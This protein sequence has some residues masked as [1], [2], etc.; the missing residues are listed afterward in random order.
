[1][2]DIRFLLDFVAENKIPPIKRRSFLSSIIYFDI[3]G[4]SQFHLFNLMANFLNIV[5]IA[6][7]LSEK[8]LDKELI[9]VEFTERD[10]RRRRIPWNSPVERHVSIRSRSFA[11]SCDGSVRD[12]L[13]TA[14]RVLLT[15]ESFSSRGNTS[16]STCLELKA[17]E[18]STPD[19]GQQIDR[20]FFASV[21][22]AMVNV[23]QM[24][25]DFFP[26]LLQFGSADS[27]FMQTSTQ[28]LS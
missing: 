16:S 1:M 23:L 21:S 20:T 7:H 24:P 5:M 28:C 8:V 15:V 2:F 14:A 25:N 11:R 4:Q 9:P 27:Q 17:S 26:D 19:D 10:L 12:P 18:R 22:D 13:S 6:R 3:G